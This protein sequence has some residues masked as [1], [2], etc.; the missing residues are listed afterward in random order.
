MFDSVILPIVL[1]CDSVVIP[2]G[3]YVTHTHKYQHMHVEQ[4]Q[5][6]PH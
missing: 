1:F 2:V 3:T 6:D 5:A 4:N